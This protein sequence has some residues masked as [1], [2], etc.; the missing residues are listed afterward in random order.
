MKTVGEILRETRERK[1]ISLL[2]AE[3]ATKIKAR[4]LEALERNDF[5]EINEATVIKG[6]I[7]NYAEYLGLSSF[8]V[9]AV[10]RRDFAE[11]KDGQILPHG[12]YKPLS[13]V[14]SI[15]TPR[16][17][18][19]LLIGF[20]F[21]SLI[22]YLLFHFFGFFSP[23]LLE[24]Y[25]PLEGEVLESSEVIVKGK[26]DPDAS[27]SING[28]LAFVFGDGSFEKKISL[29]KGKNKIL[30]EAVSRQGRKNTKEITVEIRPPD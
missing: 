16:H 5:S 17:T 11:N 22:G 30:V 18:F 13:Q 28:D 12:L 29:S 24:I 19:G 27:V 20:I 7:K 8:E 10:F 15:W 9:M 2:E 14:K 26:V 3:K 4:F 6:F 23:P 25:S 1:K 21:L